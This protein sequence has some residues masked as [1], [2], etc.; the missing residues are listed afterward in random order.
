MA[1][2]RKDAV[3][4]LTQEHEVVRGLLAQLSRAA[5]RDGR[6]SDVLR[7][8]LESE[9]SR[10]LKL[11]D[12]IFFPAFRAAANRRTDIRRYTRRR[13]RTTSWTWCC[14]RFWR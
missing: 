11:E 3:A 4:L 13:R 9:L 1:T 7:R 10:H 2:K 8:R 6:T 5:A 14:R 12:E